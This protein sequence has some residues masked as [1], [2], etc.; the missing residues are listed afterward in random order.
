MLAT[1]PAGQDGEAEDSAALA[2]AELHDGPGRARQAAWPPAASAT[3][4]PA[5]ELALPPDRPQRRPG[6]FAAAWNGHD[7]RQR[8]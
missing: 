5:A 8:P 6:Y 2:D 1:R 7:P 4:S 3:R